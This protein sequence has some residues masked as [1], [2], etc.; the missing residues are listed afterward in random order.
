MAEIATPP[1]FDDDELWT[2][3][4]VAR[5]LKT[6]MNW[7]YKAAGSGRLPHKRVLGLLRTPTGRCYV[8]ASV[9]VQE[10]G[11]HVGRQH[12]ACLVARE[13]PAE[14]RVLPLRWYRRRRRRR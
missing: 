11:R 2:A 8:V 1:P 4:D 10:R 6:S 5:Y 7:V 12:L 13:P 3:R 14:A 9:R